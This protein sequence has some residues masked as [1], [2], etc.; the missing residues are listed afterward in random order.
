MHGVG[1]SRAPHPGTLHYVRGHEAGLSGTENRTCEI[2][3]LHARPVLGPGYYGWLRG[4]RQNA[5]YTESLRKGRASAVRKEK[6]HVAGPA[7]QPRQ[8][9]AA[10]DKT[11][12]GSTG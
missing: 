10:E 9:R 5:A 1:L 4:L 2:E 3:R 12:P 7:S 8:N 6:A 11:R